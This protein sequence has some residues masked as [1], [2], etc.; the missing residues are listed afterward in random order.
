MTIIE[1]EL[2]LK[3][4][5]CAG[6]HYEYCFIFQPRPMSI[7]KEVFPFMAE[8]NELYAMDL[9]GDKHLTQTKCTSAL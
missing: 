4:F 7:E 3:S 5:Y 2:Q 8:D 6:L 1:L 9:Q